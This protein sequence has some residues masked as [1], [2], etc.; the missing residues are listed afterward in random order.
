MNKL[1][2]G[3]IACLLAICIATPKIVD[4][5]TFEVTFDGNGG[6]YNEIESQ[7][8]V[9]VKEDGTIGEE[10]WPADPIKLGYNF[11]GYDTEANFNTVFTEE[12]TLTANYQA[13]ETTISLNADGGENGDTSVQATYGSELPSIVVPTREGYNFLGYFN[14]DVQYY[15]ADGNSSITWESEEETFELIAH[16][17]AIEDVEEEIEEAPMLLGA[18]QIYTVTVDLNGGTLDGNPPEGWSFNGFV[19]T[20]DYPENYDCDSIINEWSSSKIDKEDYVFNNGLYSWNREPWMYSLSSNLTITAS[21]LEAMH[22]LIPDSIPNCTVEY[23]AEKIAKGNWI[24]FRDESVYDSYD[25]EILKL[26]PEDGYGIDY[27]YVDDVKRE[28]GYSVY[29]QSDFTV[30]PHLAK[31]YGLKVFGKLVTEDNKTDIFGDQTSSYD[32]DTKTLTLTNPSASSEDDVIYFYNGI[33]AKDDLTIESDCNIQI[34]Y[35]SVKD[36]EGVSGA[37]GILCLGNLNIEC[38]KNLTICSDAYGETSYG[39]YAKNVAINN[40]NISINAKTYGIYTTSRFIV[41]SSK[42]PYISVNSSNL[43]S[44]VSGGIFLNGAKVYGANEEFVQGTTKL[45]NQ[46]TNSPIIITYDELSEQY[47]LWVSGTRITEENKDSFNNFNYDPDTKTLNIFGFIFGSKGNAIYCLDDLNIN[48]G[49]ATT[50]NVT[51][52]TSDTTVMGESYGIYCVGDLN[53]YSDYDATLNVTSG[54]YAIKSVGIFC[55]GRLTIESIVNARTQKLSNKVQAFAISAGTWARSGIDVI[56][57][58]PD[59]IYLDST[60]GPVLNFDYA[61]YGILSGDGNPGY[62]EEATLNVTNGK[63]KG[64]INDNINSSYSNY[65]V[66]SYGTI[67]LDKGGII[68]SIDDYV[69]EDSSIVHTDE[70]MNMINGSSVICEDLSFYNDSITI[71]ALEVGGTLT[72]DNSNIK[73]AETTN[74]YNL[75]H[76]SLEKYQGVYAKNLTVKGDNAKVVSKACKTVSGESSAIY[77]KK[78]L[79]IQDGTVEAYGGK[80][81]DC[82]YG[83]YA[84]R[85]S[86][87]G[88][89]SISGGSVTASGGEVESGES[90]GLRTKKGDLNISGGTLTL[91][92]NTN[93][94]NASAVITVTNDDVTHISASA[95]N[96]NAV[97]SKEPLVLN[98]AVIENATELYVTENT[99][100]LVQNGSDPVIIRFK[101]IVDI[102]G[103]SMLYPEGETSYVYGDGPVWYEGDPVA[104]IS[105]TTTDVTDQIDEFY[106]D[107]YKKVNGEYIAI[108]GTPYEAGDYKLVVTCYDDDYD[109]KQEI[110]FSINKRKLTV[111]YD[112]LKFEFDGDAHSPELVFEGL[113]DGDVA[114]FDKE[115]AST[116]YNEEGSV[117]ASAIA[118]G[119]YKIANNIT[120]SDTF[121]VLYY[122]DDVTSNYELETGSIS[123]N[124]YIFN[125]IYTTA[126]IVTGSV[127]ES[128]AYNSETAP[129]TVDEAKIIVS[130]KQELLTAIDDG[131]EVLIYTKLDSISDDDAFVEKNINNTNAFLFSASLFA[132]ISGSTD[133][134]PI[135]DTNGK[136]ITIS[137]YLDESQVSNIV[138]SNKDY[139]VYRKHNGTITELPCRLDKVNDYY[140]FTFENDL[141]SDFAIF[142]KNK[143]VKPDSGSETNYRIL[144]NTGDTY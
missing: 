88:Q 130:D 95:A 51:V 21:Y 18:T 128:S 59:V 33:F 25:N 98:D 65:G 22:I 101:T 78:K 135:N 120:A 90:I 2:R 134:Y 53:I 41:N 140:M 110:L 64:Y 14:N 141:F 103:V 83:I 73:I 75:D 79:D 118:A 13:K 62:A 123:S 111:N 86:F 19:Y 29:Q 129:I 96:K 15:G 24:Y 63:I 17:E 32:P 87:D 142:S 23:K 55:D 10:N 39:I 109:G 57:S 105:G 58:N 44:I 102:S 91:T 61:C 12:T 16:Y 124:F 107:Y 3:L 132:S 93:G 81:G 28:I 26:T 77:V 116:I 38:S 85:D 67:N 126:N 1:L 11:V 27:W 48:V 5:T 30:T 37:F 68:A 122:E 36:F 6:L 49:N 50:S 92:G 119:K 52:Q 45:I 4:A 113:L 20:K 133:V 34:N 43:T 35:G 127:N 94:L 139:F 40:G 99:K 125:N 114:S 47:N 89:H 66:Y 121:K 42:K 100:E 137:V 108:N 82:S 31:S 9:S 7:L 60:A 80:A 69:V 71:R 117:V 143:P 74:D 115:V 136:K 84:G 56:G 76:I 106:Y 144:P 70:D 72:V 54:K 112:A 46:I 97:Y 131:K 8:R 138:G 104:T